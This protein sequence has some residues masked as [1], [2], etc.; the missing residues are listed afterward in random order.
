M[1]FDAFGF[2]SYWWFL[3][4]VVPFG[5]AVGIQWYSRSPLPR[6]R[7]IF[8]FGA[9]TLFAVAMVFLLSG[10]HYEREANG[11]C[12]WLVVDQSQ[13]MGEVD[14]DDLN[15]LLADTRELLSKDDRAGVIAFGREVRLLL[16]PTSQNKLPESL[17]WDIG[18]QG[19]ETRITTSL[20]LVAQ[21]TPSDLSPVVIL[22]SDGRDSARDNGGDPL[23]GANT[24][25]IPVYA[26][27]RTPNPKPE[28]AISAMNARALGDVE[29]MLVVNVS[30]FSNRVQNATLSV[31]LSG[32]QANGQITDSS[33]PMSSSGE[34]KLGKG[35]NPIRLNL[36][37]FER[38]PVYALE[39]SI[40]AADDQSNANNNVKMSV[41]GRGQARTLLIHGKLGP[42][43]DLIRSLREA[44]MDVTVGGANALPSDPIEL[45]RFQV[46]ILSD[47]AADEFSTSQD[48]MV[49]QWTRRGGG[50]AMIGGQDS[51]APGGWY[52]TDTEKVLPVSCEVVEKGRKQ[53]PAMVVALDRSGSM[54]A[55]VGNYTKMDLANEGCVRTIAL[56]PANAHFGMLSVDTEPDWVVPLELLTDKKQAKNRARTNSPG[57]GGIYVDVAVKSAVA[58]LSSIDA[59]SRHCVL[60]SD[61][62]DTN[63]QSGVLEMVRRARRDHKITFSVICLGRGPDEG[64]LR[65]MAR[66]GGGRF[67]LVENATQIPVIFSREAALAGGDFIRE[68]PFRP[69]H[70]I[71][72]SLTSD[73]NFESKESPQLLGYV[74]TTAKE[75]ARTWLWADKDKERPILASWNIELGRSIAFMSDARDRWADQWLEWS[76]YSPLWQRWIQW[77]EPREEQLAGVERE[78]VT[79]DSGPVLRLRFYDESGE[80]R[81]LRDP[82]ADAVS[83]TRGAQQS[84]L[85]PV[86]VGEYEVRF[87]DRTSGLYDVVVREQAAN[88]EQLVAAREQQVFAP[89]GEWQGE[90]PDRA[91]LRQLATRSMGQLIESPSELSRIDLNLVSVKTRPRMWLIWIMVAGLFTYLGARRLPT[92]WKTKLEERRRKKK[93]ESRVLS[94][95]DAFERVRERLNDRNPS[96]APPT[97]GAPQSHVPPPTPPPQQPTRPSNPSSADPSAEGS[98]LSAMRK[99]RKQLDNDQNQPPNS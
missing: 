77:L 65:D 25:N 11:R 51:F 45:E 99:V 7:Q 97:Y 31:K 8:G 34:V 39:V 41:R 42:D 26:I 54:S 74:A 91:L 40:A 59:S 66:L 63:R 20:E 76:H 80:L 88:G 21:R 98:L 94:T 69:L 4:A 27:P 50:L 64:F 23:V 83:P 47:V 32:K 73:V 36:R 1:N 90:R 71:P 93:E 58:A 12:Y 30:V 70:G 15:G 38:L 5:V 56:L 79:T 86:G 48:R 61:G 3:A 67:F 33:V 49:A 35:R 17:D 84:D 24:S 10:F 2:D 87:N 62:Q 14:S 92:V 75:E 18:L 13:S 78:W 95:R 29:P 89:L 22:V 81:M 82:R 72:G 16:E 37:P 9:L 53:T 96:P 68:K 60:F 44:G 55:N 43:K 57:G 28:V 6:I 52:S 85:K 19:Y 46:L